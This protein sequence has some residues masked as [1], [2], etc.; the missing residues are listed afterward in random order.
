MGQARDRG[1]RA[2]RQAAPKGRAPKDEPRQHHVL[3]MIDRRIERNP[4]T[5]EIEMSDHSARPS[6][7]ASADR[8]S[9]YQWD[10]TML[11]RLDRRTL[12]VQTT[13]D[14]PES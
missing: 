6:R 7:Y 2:E 9:L 11:R 10:G 4:E 3:A 8:R 14:T 13:A 12:Q 5:R 1:T